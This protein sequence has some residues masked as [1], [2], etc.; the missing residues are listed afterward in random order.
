MTRKRRLLS[1]VAPA[2]LALLLVA[3]G[4]DDDSTTD[5]AGSPG[6]DAPP[7]TTGAAPAQNTPPTTAPATTSGAAKLNL[8]TASGPEFLAAIPNFPQRMV[9][10]FLEYRPYVSIQQFRK[11]IG[12]Y[13]SAAQVTEWEKYVFVPVDPNS[14][15]AETLKQL[16]GITDANVSQLTTSRPYASNDAFLA[17]LAS[18]TSQANAATAKAMLKS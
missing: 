8:N 16:P 14:S 6:P 9:G 18:V 7:T 2:T 3:C 15:D 10:E 11:E 13:V 5:A 4:G 12:K 1:F 17:K